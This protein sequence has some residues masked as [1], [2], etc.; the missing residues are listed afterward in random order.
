MKKIILFVLIILAISGYVYLDKKNYVETKL[1]VTALKTKDGVL[2]VRQFTYPTLVMVS[3]PLYFENKLQAYGV[4]G[5]ILIA[6]KDWQGEALIA[7]DGTLTVK[8]ASPGGEF[9]KGSTLTLLVVSPGTGNVI[10][11]AAQYFPFVRTHWSELFGEMPLPAET[12]II[13]QWFSPTLLKYQLKNSPKGMKVAGVIFSDVQKQWQ[14][15]NYMFVQLELTY[16]ADQQALVSVL[17]NIF[18]KQYGLT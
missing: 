17:T 9:A 3:V 16:P 1:Q 14:T 6:P 8:L 12:K 11:N 4:A 18:I 13:A 7:A 10:Y 15:K 5:K 2:G